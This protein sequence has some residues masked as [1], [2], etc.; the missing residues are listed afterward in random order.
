MP[1]ALTRGSPSALCP[2]VRH[3][4]G[5][6]R[7]QTGMRGAYGKS[8]GTAARVNIGTILLSVRTRDAAKAACVESLRRAKYKF[9]GRQQIL[10]SKNWGFTKLKRTVYVELKERDRLIKDGVNVKVKPTSGPLKVHLAE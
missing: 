9:P 8:Y 2:A 4:P 3:S 10:E 5:A 6:R 1:T 7:L